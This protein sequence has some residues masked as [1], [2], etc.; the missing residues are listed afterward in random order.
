MPELIVLAYLYKKIKKMLEL[1]VL[2]CLYNKNQ[3]KCQN[4]NLQQHH[5]FSGDFN[6]Q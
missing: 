6:K 4:Y 2:V 3:K 1:I 5:D